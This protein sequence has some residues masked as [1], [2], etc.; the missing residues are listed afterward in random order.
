MRRSAMLFLITLGGCLLGRAEEGVP[1]QTSGGLSERWTERLYRAEDVWAYRPLQSPAI[2]APVAADHPVDAFILA[3]QAAAGVKPAPRADRR[4]L[5]RRVTYSLTGLPPSEEAVRAFVNDPDGDQRAFE[6]VVDRL[7]E[8]PH[9]GEQMARHW[10]DVVRYA[11]SSG[12][13]ND[14]ERPNAWRYRDYVVRAFNRDKPYDVFVR[15]QIAGDELHPGDVE[16][17]IATGFLRMGPWEQTAMSVPKITRQWFLDDVTDSVGQVFLGHALQCARCHDHKFDPVPTRDYYAIQAVFATTQFAEPKTAWLPDENREGF[18]ESEHL[19]AR[20]KRYQKILS[21][22]HAKQVSAAKQWYATRGLPYT[23]RKDAL[24]K[25]I[26]E[27]EIVPARHGLAP[28]DLGM[29]RIGRKTI[30]RH[31]WERDRYQPYAFAVYS[32]HT[33]KIG[34]VS[35]RLKVPQDRTDGSL[36]E[37]AILTGGDPFSPGEPVRPAV[38]SAVSGVPV[39]PI[40]STVAGRRAAFAE[41]LTQDEHPLTTRVMVNR[42]WSWHFGQG[43]A[44]NPNNLGAT[45]KKPTHPALLDWLARAFVRE[46]WSVK[47]LTR[48]LLTSQAYQRST[49]HPQPSI[50]ADR[51][52]HGTLY[53]VFPPRR[54]TAEELRDSMLFHSGELNP[55]L[56]GIPVRPDINREAALQPRMIMGT[57]APAYQPNPERHRRHRRSLYALKLR[58]LRDPFMEVFN[59]P[60]PDKSCEIRET[61]LGT[62]QVFSL[63]NGEEIHDRALGLA[64]RLIEEGGDDE[65]VLERLISRLFHRV[66]EPEERRDLLKHWEVMEARHETLTFAPRV[67]PIE[68]SRQAKEEVTGETFTFIEELESLRAYESDRQPHEADARTRA[69]ADICLVLFNSNAFA[70]VY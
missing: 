62:P 46:G 4:T 42:L 6:R 3:R 67:I 27:E 41:W 17:L 19:E 24:R 57:Y 12:F 36:E 33:R 20:I 64:H 59:Q 8:S 16:S 45:G 63:F 44:G 2:P 70:Y 55:S 38:L 58:G 28:R 35:G 10:L 14:F 32:G 47:A 21:D 49:Q 61:S 37:T 43:L 65:V 51:G 39:T 11:D 40:P 54:L 29:E 69:L 52:P 18:D 68:V 9:Y 26:P 34:V 5:I 15:E 30:A 25:G 50:V 13:A 1:M 7:L 56:G 60:G 66:I 22:I 31:Q 23:P 53:A 48:L